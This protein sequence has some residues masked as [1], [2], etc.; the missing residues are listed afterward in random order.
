MTDNIKIYVKSLFN[1]Y[2]QVFFSDNRVFAA[3]LIVVSFADLY[4][5][6]LGLLAVI[7][8]NL[9]G[10]V[11][12]FDRQTVSKGLYGFN[13]L[14]VGLGLGIYYEPG[15]VLILIIILSSILTLFISVSLQ[16]VIGKYGLPYLSVPFIIG[17]WLVTL[18]AREFDMLGISERGIFMHNEIYTFGGAKMVSLY[19]WWNNIEIARA[20]KIYFISLGAIFFQY[21]MLAGVIISIG[22]L[23]HSRI[24]FTLS[25]IGFFT[26]YMFYEVTGASI[27]DLNYSY[28][29]FNY[30]LTS[31]ALGGFF[32][33]PSW[34]S[35]L[36]TII[37]VPLVAILTISMSSVF[38]V[39]A[40][41]IFAL[42]FNIVVLLFLYILKFRVSPSISL[43][44]VV[45]QQNS[46]ERNLYSYVNDISRF[47]PGMT[48]SNLPFFG[49]WEVSQAH[50]GDLTHKGD[51]KHAWDFIISD[52]KGEQYKNEGNELSDYYCYNKPLTAVADGIVESV[53]D[54]IPDNPVGVP[55]TRENWGNTVIIKHGDYVYSS[56]SHLVPGS[57][58]VK[59]GQRVRRGE[60]LG[61]CGNSGRSPY[62][63]LHF[64]MQYSPYIGSKTLDYPIGYYLFRDGESLK[65]KNYGY[66][67]KGQKVMN[68]ETTDLISNAFDLVPGRQFNYHVNIN[69]A[70]WDERWEV[71]TDEFNNSF[72][73][74][75]KKG[76][77]AYFEN[78]GNILTFRHFEGN[79]NTLLYWFY[80][81]LYR[82]Q[83]GFY[84][85]IVIED[86]FPVNLFFR[87]SILFFQDF[88]APFV[89][90][91]RSKYR[92]EYKSIDSE[93]S[94][95]EI[96]LESVSV[97][98]IGKFTTR[99]ISS[100]IV[101]TPAG[102]SRLSLHG[103]NLNLE[104]AC[105][106]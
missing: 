74:C 13:S 41:P 5:G 30:I 38:K 60:K 6:L 85:E 68:V 99:E 45:I 59:E 104:A 101:L 57:I 66:P 72:I 75:D 28:I 91:L 93:I 63:H 10:F 27:T 42:P 9:V 100:E 53:V 80:I 105:K 33:I 69:G 24:S 86:D 17:A 55:N 29:G 18:A 8:T 58:V 31:I 19:E 46:P 103:T 83:L 97:N 88:L 22:L 52:N 90:I 40:L 76:S 34:K 56:L 4:A 39:F 65:L 54:N 1:S 12:G 32:I 64:Q 16:G 94:P 23:Y 11:M 20:L 87:K 37:L 73:K 61:Q 14:L 26:A 77:V 92:L 98:K 95:S 79:K 44:E 43:A 82:V 36:W 25:L 7:V 21:N 71:F 102:V 48:R 62:P 81:S 3:I 15:A 89:K 47:R 51:W 78:D 2:S 50:N 67:H 106:E 96:V 35:Y 49:L 70:E 84:P